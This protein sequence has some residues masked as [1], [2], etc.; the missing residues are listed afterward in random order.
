MSQ[1]KCGKEQ[2]K[3]SRE[4]RNGKKP[5]IKEEETSVSVIVAAMFIFNI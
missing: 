1:L 2:R 3:K 5:E 4:K